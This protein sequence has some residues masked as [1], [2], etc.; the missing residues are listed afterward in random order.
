MNASDHIGTYA[1]GWTN[2][3]PLMILKATTDD[4]VFDD[5]NAGKITKSDFVVYFKEL[6]NTVDSLRGGI[7]H[8]HFM[9]FTEVVPKSDGDIVTVWCWRAIPGTKI[10]GS[11]LIKATSEGIISERITYYAARPTS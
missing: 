9:D 6:K 4:F 2:G 1:E 5:P 3:D 8:P 7:E 10:Q 11:G